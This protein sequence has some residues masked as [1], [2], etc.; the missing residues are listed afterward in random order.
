ML[1]F[2]LSRL[3][4]PSAVFDN[5]II[6]VLDISKEFRLQFGMNPAAKQPVARTKDAI[7]D[8]QKRLISHDFHE[9]F[10]STKV[11]ISNL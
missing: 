9:C 5:Q 11:T 7:L 3:K 1:L 2:H 4:T 8:Q 6:I 10:S